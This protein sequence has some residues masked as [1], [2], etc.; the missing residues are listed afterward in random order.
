LRREFGTGRREFGRIDVL[1]NIAGMAHFNWI[2]DITEDE[3][4]LNTRDKVD[5]VFFMTRRR[6]N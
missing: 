2:A 5:L 1:A 4:H 3:W 6:A